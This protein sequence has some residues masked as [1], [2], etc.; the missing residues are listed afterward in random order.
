MLKNLRKLLN[1]NSSNQLIMEIKINT[2]GVNIEGVFYSA[3][4]ITIIL[5]DT[6][7]NFLNLCSHKPLLADY[8]DYST[9]IEEATNAPF[10]SLEA[11][12]TYMNENFGH[13]GSNCNSVAVKAKL[14]LNSRI[15]KFG[16]SQIDR[17]DT[18]PSAVRSAYQ[19]IGMTTF[20]DIYSFN[21]FYT[22][23]G[24][25]K[26][27]SGNTVDM[28]LARLDAALALNPKVVIIEAGTNSINSSTS[29]YVLNA[30]R[31]ITD[32]FIAIGAH[33][34]MVTVLP[35]FSPNAFDAPTEAKR[36]E[37]VSGQRLMQSENL[38][39]IDGEIVMDDPTLFA[40]GLHTNSIGADVLGRLIAEKLNAISS[41]G[42]VS[43]IMYLSGSSVYNSNLFFAGT[44]GVFLGGASGVIATSY[45]LD[46]KNSGASIVGAVTNV[47]GRNVQ[48]IILTGTY[49][50][51][52]TAIELYHDFTTVVPV[53]GDVLEGF[54]DI[55]ILTNH[56]NVL[57][58]SFSFTALTSAFGTIG[59]GESLFVLDQFS[60]RLDTG[61]KYTLRAPVITVGSGIATRVRL[62]AKIV[63]KDGTS[64]PINAAIRVHR[65]GARKVPVG[66]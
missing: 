43:D 49:N 19:N 32:A 2:N 25:N 33:V 42:R 44:G 21:K 58:I 35:R 27:V 29:V 36:I 12:V 6:K 24:G 64:L 17:G 46:G 51:L 20:A 31:L 65:I 66:I 26:G 63:L 57:G 45:V 60:N 7:V 48:D 61:V 15:I 47:E 3:R 11:L 41:E 37:V 8:V 38:D 39:V 53:T 10:A 9:I 34:I 14:P 28:M 40:D 22:P 4:S 56:E 16:D 1:T 50:G 30:L 54:G 23:I 62:Y 13:Q 59:N 52:N 55:E 5:C 18:Q